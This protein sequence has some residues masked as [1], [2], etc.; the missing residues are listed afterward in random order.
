[1]PTLSLPEH[2]VPRG[3][4][5]AWDRLAS[6]RN[7]AWYLDR[8][9][10]L[11]KR[12]IHLELIRKWVGR[13]PSGR[14][15]KTDL[16]EDA[17]G[18]DQIVFDLFAPDAAPILGMDIASATAAAAQARAPGQTL[19]VFVADVRSLPL[20]PASLDVVL[21]TSTLD[22]FAS[23][24]EFAQAF[25][26]LCE[27]LKPGGRLIIT[28][29]NPL[30]PWYPLLRLAS[31]GGLTPFRFGYTKTAGAVMRDL[32]RNGFEILDHDWL[33]H[34]PRILSTILFLGLRRLLGRH[35]DRPIRWGLALFALPG[36][37]WT[38]RFTACFFA[39][40]ARKATG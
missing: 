26:G 13:S 20:A 23:K 22:H 24:A 14:I 9:A 11:Q 21:S 39:I 2:V 10:A 17:W 16:F 7:P 30:N 8:E 28:L 18:A 31:R 40:H 15:L 37:F 29:D 3:D 33:I 38:R 12:R 32:G 6:R 25:Q 35:A 34:N 5:H 4:R 1:M 36:R 19:P 27:L